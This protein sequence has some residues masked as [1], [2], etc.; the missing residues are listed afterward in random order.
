MPRTYTIS[1]HVT[2][3]GEEIPEGH[4]L[5]IPEDRA[6]RTEGGP[7]RQG[8]YSFQ[9]RAG[10]KRVEITAT[11]PDPKAPPTMGPTYVDYIPE[12]YNVHSTLSVEV[13]P[14]GKKQ[15]DFPLKSREP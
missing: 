3:D 8:V 4:I 1:G 7:I 5:F 13:T 10:K 12:R 2:L 9:A 6:L 15:F 11:R 14:D